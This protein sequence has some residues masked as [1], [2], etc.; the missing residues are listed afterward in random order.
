MRQEGKIRE[1]HS[2]KIQKGSTIKI[3]DEERLVC[4][5][6]TYREKE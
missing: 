1:R 2:Q 4:Y 6:R 3:I 5:T